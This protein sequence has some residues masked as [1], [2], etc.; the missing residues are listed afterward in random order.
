MWRRK[1]LTAKTAPNIA[2]RASTLSEADLTMWFDQSI[3]S[4]G[5]SMTMWLR[6][7]DT[8]YIEE[9]LIGAYAT[10]AIVEEIAIRNGLVDR[11]NVNV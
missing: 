1:R 3:S 9:C 6:S 5:R 11:P 10:L 2:K 8:A 4:T 7:K